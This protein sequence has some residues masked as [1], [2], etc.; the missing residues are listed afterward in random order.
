MRHP[1]DEE[2][3]I[4]VLFKSRSEHERFCH[5][6]GAGS[7]FIYREYDDGRIAVLCRLDR[8]IN[9]CGESI[10]NPAWLTRSGKPARSTKITPLERSLLEL[11]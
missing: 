1:I 2:T 7:R 9:R 10:A 6:T 11:R 8:H 5:Q 4:I 3:E